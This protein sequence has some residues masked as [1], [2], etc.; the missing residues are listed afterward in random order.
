[1]LSA[2]TSVVYKSGRLWSALMNFGFHIEDLNSEPASP[3]TSSL[4]LLQDVEVSNQ[5]LQCIDDI[6]LLVVKNIVGE[7]EL[8]YGRD[9]DK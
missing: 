4:S 6:L 1:M 3:M 5:D 7:W 8:R 9:F 2:P